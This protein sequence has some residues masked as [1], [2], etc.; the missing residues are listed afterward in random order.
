[1][2]DWFAK[3]TIHRPPT[4]ESSSHSFNID[5]SFQSPF[6]Q[7]FSLSVDS[8]HSVASGVSALD[9]CRGPNA[10]L[11]GVVTVVINSLKR[12]LSRWLA[13][14]V[15]QEVIKRIHPPLTDANAPASVAGESFVV[16]F[17][18]SALHGMPRHKFWRAAHA[19]GGVCNYNHLRLKASA[20]P[21]VP[22]TQMVSIDNNF[23]AAAAERCVAKAL[24]QNVTV[25]ILS[26]NAKYT[27]GTE[28][29]L[30]RH[31]LE[32][33]AT[34]DSL[35]FSHDAN[36][37]VGLLVVRADAGDTLRSARFILSEGVAV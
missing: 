30:R 6:S 12:V 35:A 16:W 11:W 26:G 23:R 31:V 8:H 17:V 14:H 10:I 24:P 7:A 25:P 4:F 22:C 3:C 36:L 18:A 21:R 32:T 20:R 13:T 1:M 27:K 34:L 33:N 29:L 28:R 15:R 2:F 19:V 5:A 9:Y 37:H